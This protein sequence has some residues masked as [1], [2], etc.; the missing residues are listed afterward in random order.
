M[1]TSFLL[2]VCVCVMLTALSFLKFVVNEDTI[3]LVQIEDCNVSESSREID[4]QFCFTVTFLFTRLTT[5]KKLT[6]R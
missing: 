4:T 1:L 6:R 3:K 2:S 5:K